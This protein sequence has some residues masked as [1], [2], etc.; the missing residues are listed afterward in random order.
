MDFRDKE[1]R[2]LQSHPQLRI[3]HREYQHE[4]FVSDGSLPL[5]GQV[6]RRQLLRLRESVLSQVRIRRST[7]KLSR[8]R[9]LDD[10]ILQTV[11]QLVYFFYIRRRVY[12]LYDVRYN[13][14]Y[15]WLVIRTN[16]TNGRPRIVKRRIN[17]QEVITKSSSTSRR[18]TR[19]WTTVA[20]L[21]LSRLK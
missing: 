16:E 10:W 6:S 3:F 12:E 15:C 1:I 2:R 17:L 9:L 13:F 11:L 19:V 20:K 21:E 14:R 8:I 4:L 18:R 7:R 5:L